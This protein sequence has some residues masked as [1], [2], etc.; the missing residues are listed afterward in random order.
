MSLL[1]IKSKFILY[2]ILFQIPIKKRLEIINGSKKFY[3]KL[4]YF[5]ITKELYDKLFNYLNNNIDSYCC[6][7]YPIKSIFYTS[8]NDLAKKIQKKFPNKSNEF[9][10]LIKEIIIENIK[11]KNIYIIHYD[12]T[13]DSKFDL[14]NDDDY[15][16]SG[17]IIVDFFSKYEELF[18]FNYYKYIIKFDIQFCEML[19][20]KSLKKNINKIYGINLNLYDLKHEIKRKLYMISEKIDEESRDY[21]GYFSEEDDEFY[22]IKQEEVFDLLLE[23]LDL[24]NQNFTNIHFLKLDFSNFFNNF[25]EKEFEKI[26]NCISNF[27]KRNP[28]EIL[29]FKDD[30]HRTDSFINNYKIFI[31]S[32]N[33]LNELYFYKNFMNSYSSYFLYKAFENKEEIVNYIE[34]PNLILYNYLTDVN[35][36]IKILNVEISNPCSIN[37]NPGYGSFYTLATLNEDFSLISNFKNLEEFTLDYDWPAE[38]YYDFEGNSLVEAL[39][40]LKYLKKVTFKVRGYLSKLIPLLNVKDAKFIS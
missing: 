23:Y 37:G 5:P 7:N 29:F 1:N 20:N 15:D 10:E 30:T 35:K 25:N 39:N 16:S 21:D 2:D 18:K 32:F 9:F 26:F 36:N 22:N 31:K 38:Y 14:L 13:F 12:D 3:K 8:L 40:S 4:E 34:D 24:L 19:R 27:S 33:N 28:I 17:N 6:E 11:A